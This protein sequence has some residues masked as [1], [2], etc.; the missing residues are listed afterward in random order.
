MM[1]IASPYGCSQIVVT[2]FGP[3]SVSNRCQHLVSPGA[4]CGSVYLIP[5]QF[6]IY[7]RVQPA[8]CLGIHPGRKLYH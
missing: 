1:Q 5:R 2:N 4:A 8:L 3:W 6:V 7:S